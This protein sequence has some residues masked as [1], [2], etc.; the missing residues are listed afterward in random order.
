ME[1]N[2]KVSICIPV[3]NG[4]K[5]IK[6]TILSIINQTYKNIEII[7]SD[8]KST[9]NTVSVVNEFKDSRISFYKNDSNIGLARNWNKCLE[10]CTGKYIHFICADDTLSPECIEEKV[11]IMESDKD[12]VMVINTMNM[13]NEE[14]KIVMKRKIYNKDTVI[15]GHKF[16]KKSLYRGNIYGGPSNVLFRKDTLE[17]SGIFPTNTY[18]TTDWEFTLRLSPLGKIVYL[19]KALTHYIISRTNTTSKT[20]LR[21]SLEDDAQMIKNLENYKYLK[22]TFLDKMIHNIA[23]RIRNYARIIYMKYFFR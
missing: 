23:I 10:K 18:Y 16:A 4:E 20:S 14:K 6:D 3:Y 13:Y 2:P 7:I 21:V 12:V 19:E 1:T 17:K 11:K 15:D 8:N 22:I 5:T 9:D